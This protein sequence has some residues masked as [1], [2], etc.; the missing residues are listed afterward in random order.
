MLEKIKVYIADDHQLLIDGIIAVLGSEKNIEVVGYSLNGEDVID[1]FKK[2][3]ADI[4]ILDI[5]MPKIDGVGVLQYFFK[6]GLQQKVI[7]LSSYDDTKLI[8]EV[9]K[10]GASGFLAKKC[11]AE[12]IIEAINVVYKGKQYFSKSIQDKLIATFTNNAIKSNRESIESSFFS[13][14][15]PREIEVLKLIAEQYSSKE[16]SKLLHISIN[17]VETHRKNLISK[18]N[19]KNVVGLAIYAVKNNIV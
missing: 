16:I 7:I 10:I 4:L 2:N 14:L 6:K 17:T 12:N 1:W 15:T 13:S 11:A 18:L 19:V 9:L 5:N 8:K 3:T